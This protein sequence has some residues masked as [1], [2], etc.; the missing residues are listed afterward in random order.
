LIIKGLDNQAQLSKY[1]CLMIEGFDNQVQEPST[2][3]N[4]YLKTN[5]MGTLEIDTNPADKDAVKITSSHFT[6]FEMIM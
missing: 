2:K 3:I 4:R 1:I 5:L 6:I